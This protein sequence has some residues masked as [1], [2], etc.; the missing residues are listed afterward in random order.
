VKN[1][2]AIVKKAEENGGKIVR[3]KHAVPG[4]GWLV[5]IKDFEGIVTG[6]MQ[7]DPTAK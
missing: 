6:V 2:D 4:V 1:V 5:Y 7:E 3:P